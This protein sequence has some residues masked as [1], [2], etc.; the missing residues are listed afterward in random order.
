[1]PTAPSNPSEELKQQIREFVDTIPMAQVWTIN[2]GGFPVGRSVGATLRD[3]WNINLIQ[4]KDNG[5]VSQVRLHPEMTLEWN[6][7]GRT[8]GK[9]TTPRVIFLRGRGTLFD[10]DALVEAYNWRVETMKRRTG[11]VHHQLSEEEVRARLIGVR[12]EPLLVRA[13][14]FGEGAEVFQWVP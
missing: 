12:V 10:G 1:M 6:D 2:S 5:R 8:T 14:G 4:A 11:S 13:E 3:G 9:L 7:G